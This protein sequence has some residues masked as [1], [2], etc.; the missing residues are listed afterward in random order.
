MKAM[1]FRVESP[2]HSRQIQE[3]LFE[4]G[5]KWRHADRVVSHTDK[6]YLST[7]LDGEITWDDD[8]SY[9]NTQHRK[10]TTLQ[11][12]QWRPKQG[13]MI[14]VRD[15]ENSEWRINEFL[16]YEPRAEK[17]FVTFEKNMGC[18]FGWKHARPINTIQRDIDELQAKIDELKKRL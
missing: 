15:Y 2:E 16:Y 14:E 3:R 8:D 1:K 9:F 5:Y 10:E 13:E 18:I 7:D 4:M 6:K 17:P 11:D 12:I